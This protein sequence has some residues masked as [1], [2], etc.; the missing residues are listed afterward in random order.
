MPRPGSSYEP[1]LAAWA[2][3]SIVRDICERAGV[4]YDRFN[5]DLVEGYCDGF[6][7]TGRQSG[8]AAIETL[9]GIFLFDPSNY[10]GVLHF[11][12]RG[13]PVVAAIT[14]D[15]FIDEETS[16][17]RADSIT[18]PN[19]INLEYYDTEG[20]LTPDKQTSDRVQGGRNLSDSTTETTVL[21]RA[22]DA[23]RSVVISHKV[24]IEEAR[25]ERK[26][27]LPIGWLSLAAADPITVDGARMRI[28]GLEI[29][30]NSQ[31]YT[32]MFDRVTAYETSI[33]GVPIEQPSTPPSLVAAE[34]RFE[35]L[36]IPILETVDDALGVYLAVAPTANN[37]QGG[38]IEMSRDGGANWMLSDQFVL[39]T[40]MGATTDVLAEHPHPW[41][42][43]VNSVTVQLLRDDM[44]LQSATLTEMLNRS[45]L[46]IIGDEII[47]FAEVE[48]L[49]E[50]TWRLSYFLRGRK[51][52]VATTHTAGERFVLLDLA[53]LDF[54]PMEAFDLG[55]TITVRGTSIGREG[56]DQTQTLVF[57]GRSQVERQP[58]YLEARRDGANLIAT[59]RGVGRTGGGM[60]VGMGQFFAGYQVQ[61]GSQS[62]TV[63]Q[64]TVTI[65]YTAGTLSVRQL[66]S[67]TG[68]GPAATIGV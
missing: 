5:V 19:V 6:S 50:R 59:W 16:T 49:D 46:A 58:A 3:G 9:G 27:S 34:T 52:T 30:V 14:T 18:V 36:D 37:W 54:I 7:T 38:E 20:G 24:A 13:G 21:M 39:N 22:D 47:N 4:P 55:R 17:K 63:L 61:L 40:T 60:N 67:I 48:Q 42:D 65:P 68:P 11:L 35:V 57:A 32:A 53:R 1:I 62:W 29:D 2:V 31:N 25:G 51:G 56:P 44:E 28:T 64:P 66:N 8:A 45:N 15:D 10:D 33:R 43:R 41:P 23:A 26:F 12:P